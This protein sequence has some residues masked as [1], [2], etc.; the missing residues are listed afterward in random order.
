MG[1]DMS[2][3]RTHRKLIIKG[4]GPRPAPAK[5]GDSSKPPGAREYVRLHG[6]RSRSE[7]PSNPSDSPEPP[8]G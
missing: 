3:K 5:V 2:S 6:W 8:R 7:A 4:T 1:N